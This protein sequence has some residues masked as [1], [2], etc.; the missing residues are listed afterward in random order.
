[1]SEAEEDV[2]AGLPEH[3]RDFIRNTDN[4]RPDVYTEGMSEMWDR[5]DQGRCQACN[6]KLGTSTTIILQD[7][8]IAGCFCSGVCMTDMA[9]IGWL[10]EAHDDIVDKMKFRGGNGDG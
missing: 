5:F 4:D 10:Q 6:A 2:Y 8:G 7:S 9:N 3:M 1:M